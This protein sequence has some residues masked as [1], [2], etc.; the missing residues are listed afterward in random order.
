[1][2]SP[3]GWWN[4]RVYW[5]WNSASRETSDRRLC[6]PWN[7]LR[8]ASPVCQYEMP[9]PGR[10]SLC[11]WSIPPGITSFNEASWLP[12]GK[13]LQWYW[14][15]YI[16]NT[17]TTRMERMLKTCQ[18]WCVCYNHSPQGDRP[19]T[20]WLTQWL[21]S[22]LPCCRHDVLLNVWNQPTSTRVGPH[23]ECNRNFGSQS[24]HSV[25]WT[26]TECHT[27]RIV[28]AGVNEQPLAIYP[29]CLAQWRAVYTV[30]SVCS[31][32]NYIRVVQAFELTCCH[33]IPSF[34]Y[35]SCSCFKTISMNSC[36]SF[37]LQ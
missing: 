12:D 29:W 25:Q 15:I 34:L 18:C 32:L 10:I 22:S 14:H 17:S 27:D 31:L 28:L 37:S 8:R 11:C 20:G 6:R 26:R 16:Y 23:T 3:C 19:V 1:M 35:S 33:L 5:A 2:K 4:D 13:T 21:D 30:C 9:Q 36:C 24:L 7:R